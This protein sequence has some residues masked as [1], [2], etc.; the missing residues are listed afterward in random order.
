MQERKSKIVLGCLLL[1]LVITIIL[2]IIFVHNS[3]NKEI[4]E[5]QLFKEITYKGKTTPN[6][7]YEL[8]DRYIYVYDKINSIKFTYNKETK[9]LKDWFKNDKDFIN[10]FVNEL[11]K[12]TKEKNEFDGGSITYQDG[13]IG[14][15]V[16]NT[17]DKNLNIYIGKDLNYQKAGCN[18][19]KNALVKI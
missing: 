17:L 14:I 15:V 5:P 12:L 7:Y 10:K 9:E 13:N 18:I 3:N 11:E 19:N 8:E 6:L 2:I 4:D 16:C 1:G